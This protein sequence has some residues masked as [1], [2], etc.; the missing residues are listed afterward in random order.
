MI[1]IALLLLLFASPAVAE[2]WPEDLA[3]AGECA[4]CALRGSAHGVEKYV[5]WR[6]YEGQSYGFCS[7]GC[8]EAF[9]QMPSGYAPPVLP[10]PAPEFAWTDLGG[11]TITPTGQPALLIDF[12]ATWCAPCLTVI[13][14]LEKLNREFGDDLSVVGVSI[15]EKRKELDKYLDR[16]PI[17][18]AVVHDGGD[19][20]AWWQF[21]VPA[22]P[23]AF[24][25]NAD[26]EIVA[27]WNG[28]V[29]PV[30]VR[31]AVEKMLGAE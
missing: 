30:E 11:A 20:P 7:K 18:Y 25:L 17:S 6:E 8:A 15:D 5:D 27:Q 24:L 16:R 26:G 4:V 28:E 10:R 29:D 1:R 23:A 21:R 14:E 2:G 31:Q 19:D 3:E 22:I 12:W 13:P 9:D